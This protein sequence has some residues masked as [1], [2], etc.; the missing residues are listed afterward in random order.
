MGKF[1]GSLVRMIE[2]KFLFFQVKI[3]ERPEDEEVKGF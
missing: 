1:I 2:Q 3:I